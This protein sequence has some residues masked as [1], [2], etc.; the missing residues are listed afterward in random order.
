MNQLINSKYFK[1]IVLLIELILYALL[2]IYKKVIDFDIISHVLMIIIIFANLYYLF[3]K[4][5]KKIK[6]KRKELLLLLLINLAISFF[7]SGKVLFLTNN[8]MDIS[9]GSMF[10]YLLVN[11]FVFPFV[12]NLVYLLDSA[13]IIDNKKEE[14]DSK[15]F[16]IKIFF[17]TFISWLVVCLIFYPGNITSD[18][19]DIIS[20]AKGDFVINNAHPA[21]FTIAIRMLLHLWNNIF[22]IVLSN[23]LFFSFVLAHIYRYLYEQKVNTKFLYLSL[24][25]FL[26]SINNLSMITMAWKDLPFTIAMLWLTFES[27]KITKQKGE[28]FKN[29]WNIVF[30][31]ISM[32]LT[33]YLRYN[34]MFPFLIM[35]LYL[36]F[37]TFKY[38]EKVRIIITMVLCIFSIWFVKGPVYDYYEVSKSD[39]ISGGAASF[40]AKG[41]GALIYY[42]GDLSSEDLEVISQLAD[43]DDLKEFYYA[44]SIDT[45]SFQDIKF[46]EGIEKLGVAKIYEMYIKQFFKNPKIIIRDRLDGSNLLWSFDTPS[47]G[48]NYKYDSGVIYPNWVDDIK[49]FERNKGSAYFPKSNIFKTGV[50]IYQKG[51]NKIILLDSFFWRGGMILSILLVLLYLIIIR[52]IPIMPA[53][54]PTLISVLFWFAL[55]NHQ[56]YRYLWFLYVNTFFLIIFALLEKKKSKQ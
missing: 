46:N 36:L 34:G 2:F 13:Q 6:F 22:V 54:Y 1:W 41:L 45:Y 31:C 18:T 38:K 50:E 10:F 47:Q 33:Y 20:Q 8:V 48:F 30:F 26:L 53:T 32:T 14:R 43:L 7:V 49:G 4:S 27:Y 19:V 24:I 11:V 44:Y 42:D 17:I 39:G 21:L 25:F 28:Y 5:F 55:L 9:F 40:A 3:F 15:K 16:A 37:I 52:K 23:V 56:S 51:V 35:I 12:Y 29:T